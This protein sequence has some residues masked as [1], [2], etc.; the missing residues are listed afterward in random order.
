MDF[1]T[2]L[3]DWPQPVLGVDLRSG[4]IH[5]L[6]AAAER[7]LG[8]PS[9]PSPEERARG[10]P[11]PHCAVDPDRW[12]A[13]CRDLLSGSGGGSTRLLLRDAAGKEFAACLEGMAL[14]DGRG[15]D[16]LIFIRTDDPRLIA[17]AY[18]GP[19]HNDFEDPHFGIVHIREDGRLVAS[20]RRALRMLGY[21]TWRELSE[22][23]PNLAAL[24]QGAPAGLGMAGLASDFGR[25][26]ERDLRRCG[27]SVLRVY[28]TARKIGI[29]GHAQL[30]ELRWLDID[31]YRLVAE[32]LALC[33][34]KYRV[35]VENSQDGVFIT[36]Q[37]LY[38][39]VNRTYAR[40]LGRTVEDMVGRPFMEFI[41]PEDRQRMAAMWRER[42]A[43]RWEKSSY[44]IRLLHRIEG[45][46]VLASVRSGPIY[47]KGK[48][49]STGTIR[50]ITE[51]R[52]AEEALREVRRNYQ[53]IFENLQIAI[54]QTTL[55]GRLLSANQAYAH[56]LGYESVGQLLH[57]LRSVVDLYVRREDRDRINRVLTEKGRISGIEIELRRRDGRSVWGMLY[58]RLVRPESGG[59]AYYEGG[60][61]DVTERRR[62]EQ[63]LARSEEFYRSLVEHGHV[64]VFW[65]ENDRFTY[66]NE[67]FANALGYSP[68]ELRGHP[69]CDT[70][71]PRQREDV[72]RTLRT[73]ETAP[74]TC[75]CDFVMKGNTGIA[76][77]L[78]S[79]DTPT[80]EDRKIMVATAQDISAQ[81]KA[82]EQLRIQSRH[83]PLT[84][85]PNRIVFRERLSEA[86]RK[87]LEEEGSGY[88][89]LFLDLDAFKLVNDT[90]G[91]LVGDELLVQAARRIE[92]ELP[93]GS[94]LCRHGGDEFTLL[95]EHVSGPSDVEAVL[96]RLDDA[97]RQPFLLQGQEVF[98]NASIGIVLGSRD[99][100]NPEDILRDADT[101]MYEAKKRA[102][103]NH[104]FFDTLMR[105]R[106]A[107]RLRTET[108][109]RHAVLHKEFVVVY[110][111]IVAL[112]DRRIVG[113]EA[114]L[115]WRQGDG[116][117]ASPGTF[118]D[119]AE[120]IGLTLPL[121][122]WFL[123]EIV[124]HLDL[125]RSS[126]HLPDAFYVSF[127]LSHRQFFDPDLV[128]TIRDV[129]A[130]SGVC[131]R[132]LRA[133]VT[134][135]VIFDRF[136][137]AQK[138]LEDFRTMGLSVALDD[139]GTGYSS[140]GY[141]RDLLLD[142]LKIDRSFIEDI[143]RNER[144]RKI[145][146]SLIDLSRAL[147]MEVVAEGVETETQA[148]L[149]RRFRCPCVQ[150]YY[151][152][153]PVD[154]EETTMLL[155][156]TSD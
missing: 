1:P 88:A 46:R 82:W 12:R 71:V 75:E 62:V 97:L 70:I 107:G 52:R 95:L 122:R 26:V 84:G 21:E 54:F 105:T 24:Y 98:T 146:T 8:R 129:L 149:L 90:L 106:I 22:Q 156:K 143:E 9:I 80:V 47:Y 38:V 45:R 34:E 78:V 74:L 13:Y 25:G 7:L 89:V 101:A 138:I 125:W 76:S 60:L 137:S 85:L 110:Q 152:S 87:H 33:Q 5:A 4:E 61:V 111:P 94:L 117:R 2:L 66:V 155:G 124:R 15:C 77:M 40:M 59:E 48:L 65:V 96:A 73:A 81:R 127:N 67:A 57:E 118:L 142:A 115:R 102:N 32:E 141:L 23:A 55:A 31:A 11:L 154:F 68:D 93:S 27:G 53:E 145:V 104:A 147:G 39:Y 144:T 148:E 30:W 72:A 123:T 58:S 17:G 41:A 139:F 128:S 86:M 20:N 18:H 133:E 103:G 126:Q 51:E 130:R 83:D 64:G 29:E 69:V 116:S 36:H 136:G 92:Q 108:N 50:D 132:F 16:A 119:I 91:H 49:S 37:G 14:G 10:A 28:E 112:A 109:L 56:F 3:N 42:E 134:E 79:I 43:G 44:E 6:N 135:T 99:Y 35:L 120:D 150:G 121:N 63:A 100:A 140:F 131:P 153:P 151:F 114:L 113:L 19:T